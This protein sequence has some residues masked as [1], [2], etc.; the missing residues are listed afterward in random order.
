MNHMKHVVPF[1]TCMLIA[2]VAQAKL[3]GGN[4][5]FASGELRPD[6]AARIKLVLR[7]H[8]ETRIDVKGDGSKGS[9]VDCYLYVGDD[10]SHVYAEDTSMADEC[11]FSVTPQGT[12]PA[13]FNMLV[14]NTSDHSVRY[15]VVID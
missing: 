15:S 12:Q 5:G 8:E 6:V 3:V 2:L 4:T 7:P 14:Q 10:Q 9:D 13:R 11:H 1:V